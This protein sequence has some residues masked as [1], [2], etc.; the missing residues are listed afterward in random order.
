MRAKVIFDFPH[1]NSFG[2]NLPGKL[3][4][5]PRPAAIHKDESIAGVDEGI[6]IEIIGRAAGMDDVFLTP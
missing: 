4:K 6:Y 3:R 2:L 1:R 5:N